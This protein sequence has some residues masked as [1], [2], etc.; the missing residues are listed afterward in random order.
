MHKTTI[1]LPEDLRHDIEVLAKQEKR[2]KADFIR[3]ALKTYVDQR[4]RRLPKS[5]GMGQDGALPG[6]QI[7]DWLKKNWAKDLNVDNA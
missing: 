1:Y 6:D 7:D 5:I 4:P 3:N 2:S